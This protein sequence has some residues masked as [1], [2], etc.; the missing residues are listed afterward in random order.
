MTVRGN[1]FQTLLPYHLWTKKS[2]LCEKTFAY[3]QVLLKTAF[4][5]AAVKTCWCFLTLLLVF[6]R[7]CLGSKTILDIGSMEVKFENLY[8]LLSNKKIRHLLHINGR[9]SPFVRCSSRIRWFSREL[10]LPHP[11]VYRILINGQEAMENFVFP[12]EIKTK[13]MKMSKLYI[14]YAS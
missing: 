2:L 6:Q 11:E 9:C 13:L 8:P 1:D 3:S 7:K 12:D 5:Y 4:C 10:Y 14:S